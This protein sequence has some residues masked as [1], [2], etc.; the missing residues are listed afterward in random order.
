MRLDQIVRRATEVSTIPQVALKVAEI[1]EDENATASAIR[2]V[3]E[4]DAPL[5]ARVLRYVNSSAVALRSRV[6]NLRTAI[7]YLGM[8]QIRNL[9]IA[10]SV[11]DVFKCQDR[12]GAYSRAGLWRHLVAVAVCSQKLAMRQRLPNF[13]DA[14]LAGLLH[15]IGIILADQYAH[16]DFEQIMLSPT[17]SSGTLAEAER[18]QLGFDHTMLGESLAAHWRLPEAVRSAISHHHASTLCHGPESAIVACVE[19]ANLVC[20]FQGWTS[21]GINL[22]APRKEAVERF[23]LSAEDLL[24]LAA[25]TEAELAQ[26]Q[27]LLSF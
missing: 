10:A 15:D 5:S 11:C 18:R 9:A 3:M 22:V 20:S 6:T 25:D 23:G 16:K 1:T 8:R 4:S 19:V 26:R 27:G 2:A 14:F 17:L 24:M 21:V 13:E 12:I 7:S